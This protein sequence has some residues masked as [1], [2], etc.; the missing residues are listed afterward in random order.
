MPLEKFIAVV[1]LY[2]LNFIPFVYPQFFSLTSNTIMVDTKATIACALLW[3]F[4]AYL[5]NVPRRHCG[6]FSDLCFGSLP[7]RSQF[8]P[9]SQA[10]KKDMLI[11]LLTAWH[12]CFSGED[13]GS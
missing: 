5:I 3:S 9:T 4:S 12:L 1:V 11:C 8:L 7:S 10:P 13:V 2:V 6:T